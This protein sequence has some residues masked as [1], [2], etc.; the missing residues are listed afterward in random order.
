MVSLEESLEILKKDSSFVKWRKQNKDSYM[1][2]CLRMLS[3]E[4][5]W[6]IGFFNKDDSMTSF[7]VSSSGITVDTQKEIFKSPDTTIKPLI[8][9]DIVL[10]SAKAVSIAE[11]IMKKEFSKEVVSKKIIILQSLSIGQVYNITFVTTA[12][13]A[14]NIKLDSKT[15]DVLSKTKNSLMDFRMKEAEK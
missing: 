9:S 8:E 11:E 7:I 3:D 1:C 10:T 13:N 6:H 2:H 4:D 12:M 14:V 15:G 5:S